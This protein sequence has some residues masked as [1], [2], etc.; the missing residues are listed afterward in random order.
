MQVKFENILAFFQPFWY[1]LR[2]LNCC[3]F[4]TALLNLRM[5]ECFV[6][7]RR[8]FGVRQFHDFLEQ[9]CLHTRLQF[10]K[11]SSHRLPGLPP[12]TCDA[13]SL[14]CSSLMQPQKDEL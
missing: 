5:Y 8:F 13:F 7:E 9:D 14:S 3:R 6:H 11:C 12:E 4:F 2:L 1:M 10:K